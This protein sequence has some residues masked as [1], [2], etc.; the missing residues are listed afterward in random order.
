MK[1]RTVNRKKSGQIYNT[2]VYIHY[3]STLLLVMRLFP[4]MQY[5]AL[6][7]QIQVEAHTA[8]L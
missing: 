8:K 4:L 1:A 3:K 5:I 6:K 2:N 7:V